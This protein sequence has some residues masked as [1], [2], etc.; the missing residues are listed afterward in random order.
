VL[1]EKKELERG[2]LIIQQ[3]GAMGC[4]GKEDT[5]FSREIKLS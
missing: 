4:T 3:G 1:E 5:G 2:E